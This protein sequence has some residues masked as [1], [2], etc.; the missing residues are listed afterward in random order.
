[1]TRQTLTAPGKSK[2]WI[3]ATGKFKI[4]TTELEHSY[5]DPLDIVRIA[6][7]A[8]RIRPSAQE[9]SFET[10]WRRVLKPQR[11]ED[12]GENRL[13]GKRR[14]LTVLFFLGTEAA[15]ITTLVAKMRPIVSAFK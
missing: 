10:R 1:L 15:S 2:N 3:T 12:F 5:R 7:P 9:A 4:K 14:I 13:F 6:K 8:K 11:G